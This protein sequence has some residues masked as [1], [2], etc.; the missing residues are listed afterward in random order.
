MY[1]E[2]CIARVSAKLAAF[3][4]ASACWNW[5]ASRTAAGYGQLTYR[6][7][8]K[9]LLAYA[10]RVAFFIATGNEASALEVC[11]R[12]DNP[13]CF[14]PSHLFMG[15]HSENS[16][17]MAAKGRGNVG[18]R[19]PLGDRHWTRKRAVDVIR[20]SAHA[21]SKVTE[22]E[23]LHILS[24][25][26]SGASLARKFGITESAISAIRKRKVWRHV[27]LSANSSASA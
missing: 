18:K 9:T 3:A 2:S 17:D 19:F 20:G 26:D 27:S 4:D 13:A 11:H 6:R 10:H 22:A 21:S 25:A 14:N 8:G 12:C 5:P 24:S 1:S 7:D 23:V 16:A 15:T